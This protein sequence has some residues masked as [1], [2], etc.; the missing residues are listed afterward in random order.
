LAYF[1]FV[2]GDIDQA[3]ALA[4][5][6]LDQGCPM[7]TNMFIRPFERQLRESPG[8]AVLMRRLN[9]PEAL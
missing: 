7:T 2:K 8:W 4:G 5:Q 6:A 9:L 1:H 3:V